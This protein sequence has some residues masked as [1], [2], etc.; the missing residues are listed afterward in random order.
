MKHHYVYEIVCLTSSRSYIGVHSTDNMEDGYFGSGKE[1]LILVTE[2]GKNN[3]LKR[4]IYHGSNRQEILEIE[5]LLVTTE[6]IKS[7]QLL[8]I[9]PGG[10]GGHSVKG[11]THRKGYIP[12]EEHRKK[13]GA[14]VRERW[15]NPE[16]K[17]R[18][19]ESRRGRVVSQETKEKMSKAKVLHYKD[20]DYRRKN[21]EILAKARKCKGMLNV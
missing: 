10:G 2:L 21:A 9:I 11:R 18:F 20:P 13:I 8:N 15:Q 17:R 7:F 3:F 1:L 4:I 6:N 12:S 5:R 14:A 19:S 16:Y